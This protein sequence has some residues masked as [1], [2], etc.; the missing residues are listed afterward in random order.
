MSDY[1]P[2]ANPYL[3][4]GTYTPLPGTTGFPSSV[5]AGP[6]DWALPPGQVPPGLPPDSQYIPGIYNTDG[7]YNE[8]HWLVGKQSTDSD[9][10]CATCNG[11]KKSDPSKGTDQIK[12][13]TSYGD[14]YTSTTTNLD[15]SGTSYGFGVQSTPSMGTTTSF[16][17]QYGSTDGISSTVS[18][19]AFGQSYSS[20]QGL[21]NPLSDSANAQ[22][23]CTSLTPSS[24]VGVSLGIGGIK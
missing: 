2:P 6:N 4:N 15:G 1:A 10:G 12:T 8:P 18:G 24:S 13:K 19:S 16:C 21:A 22:Q 20:A 7:T 14:F 23:V 3:Q 5:G 9:D 11:K 17:T